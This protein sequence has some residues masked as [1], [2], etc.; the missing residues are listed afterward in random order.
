M[1]SYDWA[2]HIGMG[3]TK[4]IVCEKYKKCFHGSE[5]VH[6]HDKK[7]FLRYTYFFKYPSTSV[8]SLPLIGEWF[9]VR[10]FSGY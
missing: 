8:Y 9:D 10:V 5:I 1:V 4:T 7:L 3:N 2:P 6:T